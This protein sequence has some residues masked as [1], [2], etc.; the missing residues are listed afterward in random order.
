[1]P[2]H[3]GLFAHQIPIAVPYSR[4]TVIHGFFQ[5]RFDLFTIS[6][7]A[8]QSLVGLLFNIL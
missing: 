2:G 7:L 8:S 1:M 4:Y 5:C 6:Q 3:N